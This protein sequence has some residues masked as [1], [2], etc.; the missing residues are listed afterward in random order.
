MP[1][2]GRPQSDNPFAGIQ[3]AP[4]R[5]NNQD[6]VNLADKLNQLAGREPE[7]RYKSYE[8]HT[9][10]DKNGFLKLLSFQLQNQNPLE[11]MDQKDFAADLAQFSQLE[12][13]T[14]MNANIEKLGGNAAYEEKFFGASFLGKEIFT[15]GQTVNYDG[16]ATGP[17]IPFHLDRRAE[18][19]IVRLYDDKGQIMA[20]IEHG[21]MPEGNQS[22]RWNGISTDG[23][24]APSGEYQ[25]EVIGWDDAGIHFPGQTHSSGLVTGVEFDRGDTVL[26]VDDGRRVFLRDV[27]SFQLPEQTKQAPVMPSP[28]SEQLEQV[29]EASRQKSPGLQQ[30]AVKAYD[31]R[32]PF[33]F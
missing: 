9:Q 24:R 3:R 12:Q 16:S 13:M 32:R 23:T 7:S 14:N 5:S 25:V 33:N 4:S 29:I 8:E 21:Q 30:Q 1:Q 2:I 10:L 15:E 19:L 26:I 27:K 17:L 18:N 22:I 28:V 6:D 31:Q 20:Q 11:P